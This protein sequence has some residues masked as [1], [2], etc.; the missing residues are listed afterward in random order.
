MFR[1]VLLIVHGTEDK[2]MDTNRNQAAVN[3]SE[4]NNPSDAEAADQAL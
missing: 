3:P 1:F 4:E 2:L